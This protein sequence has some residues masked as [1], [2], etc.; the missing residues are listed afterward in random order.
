M[1]PGHAAIVAEIFRI[2][3]GPALL[4][5][6]FLE[7]I[8]NAVLLGIG[9]RSFARVEGHADLAFRIGRTG[10]AHEGL[11][12]AILHYTGENKPWGI[13]SGMLQSVAYARLYRHV[14]T[15]ELFYR[16]AR[17]RWKRWWKRKL[18]LGR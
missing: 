8:G 3:H 7:V 17:H 5:L 18:G 11:D 16:F 13:F 1:G 4:G 12:P 9:D 10:K 2:G 15:N 6:W 14:M